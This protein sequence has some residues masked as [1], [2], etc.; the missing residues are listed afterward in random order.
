MSDRIDHRQ[1]ARHG[2]S[3]LFW[4]GATFTLV[5]PVTLAMTSS[6]TNAPWIAAICGAFITFVARFDEVAEL[7]L[8]PVKARMRETVARAAAT[9]DELRAIAT[10]MAAAMLRDLIAGHFLGGLSLANR[11]SIHDQII[12]SLEKLN[13]DAEQRA[14]VEDGWKKGLSIVY[15]KH[16]K[17]ALDTEMQRRLQA[18][19]QIDAS[20]IT[21]FESLFRTETWLAPT[22][23]EVEKFCRNEGLFEP[24]TELW[25][26]DYRHFL[27]TGEIRRR[28]VFVAD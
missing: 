12:A 14:Q 3:V 20:K 18:G 8:G 24:E 2:A 26:A 21:K 28:E 1:L 22:P 23:D 11:V 16:V 9:I 7:S 25:I 5:V 15:Y 10:A 6:G 27:A 4:V 13:I 17:S 19:K